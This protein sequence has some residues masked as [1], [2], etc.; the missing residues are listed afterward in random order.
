[1]ISAHPNLLHTNNTRTPLPPPWKIEK[2]KNDNPAGKRKHT[3]EGNK[4]NRVKKPTEH[5]I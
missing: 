2:T 4:G 5:G 3:V 1:L